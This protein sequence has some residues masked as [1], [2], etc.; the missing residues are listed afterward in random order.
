M[1]LDMY[2]KAEKY[3]K[4]WKHNYED[5]VI[6]ADT[7]AK[8][9]SKACGL[10]FPI[11]TVK[12]DVGYWRKANAIHKW[13]VDNVQDGEDECREHYVSL[14]QLQELRTL[15]DTILKNREQAA[16]LLPAASGF[17]FGSTEYD[18]WYFKDL[19]DTINIVDAIFANPDKDDL[20]YS[21]RSS[22]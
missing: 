16:E 19:E 6:P 17:F 15:C 14:E 5:N 10:P 8:L 9:I 7:T 4:D 20:E 1:G 3:V 12:A 21:Y 22:W 18:E 2:L 11:A 13:F